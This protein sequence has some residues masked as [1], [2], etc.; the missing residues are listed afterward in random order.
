MERTSSSRQPSG[1]ASLNHLILPWPIPQGIFS[2]GASRIPTRARKSLPDLKVS[3]KRRSKID[4]EIPVAQAGMKSSRCP[5]SMSG[6]RTK[7][8]TDWGTEVKSMQEWRA[9]GSKEGD[10]CWSSLFGSVV[11]VGCSGYKRGE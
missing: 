11:R 4:A 3:K 8:I 5:L 10:T 7:I 1:R 9:R 6:K 2:I